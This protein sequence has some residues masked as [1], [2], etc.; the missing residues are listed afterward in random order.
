MDGGFDR[1]AAWLRRFT[2]DAE[3][4]LPAFARR[5]SEAMP[6]RV[7]LK[8]KRSLFGAGRITGLTIRF[9]E[10]DYTLDLDGSHL[11]AAVSL[12]VRGVTLNTRELPPAEWFARLLD[13]TK[14]ETANAEAL[15]RSLDAFM[16][17]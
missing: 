7:T 11:R 16:A 14:Q 8:E 13:E 5:L 1:D 15:A 2:A 17:G 3:G 12:T 4:Q 10:R 9:S 6:D